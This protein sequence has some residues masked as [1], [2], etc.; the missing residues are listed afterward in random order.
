[1]FLDAGANC[2]FNRAEPIEEA[3]CFALKRYG[4]FVTDSA[5]SRFAIGFEGSSNGESGGSGPSPY[6]AGG[7]K[8]DYYDMKAI[9]W[10][11]LRVAAG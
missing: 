10:P 8:W 2:A 6:A 3:V 1:V 11:D 9:P 5:G 7:L 4:A